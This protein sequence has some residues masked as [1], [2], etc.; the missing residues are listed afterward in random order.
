MRVK[1]VTAGGLIKNETGEYLLMFRRGKWDL[2]KGKQDPGE[3]LEECAI[4]EVQEETGLQQVTLGNFICTTEHAYSEFGEDV[5]KKAH[6]YHMTAPKD[7]AL[8]PQT[9][10]D[11]TELK[12][13]APADLKNYLNNTYITILEVF[14][15]SGVLMEGEITM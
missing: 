15:R 8:V 1:K 4:R 9:E 13:V 12:W 14:T 2:P 6:W 11:I 10:E 5:L 7:Q 3:T